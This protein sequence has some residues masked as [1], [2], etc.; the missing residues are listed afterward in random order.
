MI[1][2]LPGVSVCVRACMRACACAR[3]RARVCV[4]VCVCV[5]VR[6]YARARAGC[7]SVC[8]GRTAKRHGEC[9]N[10]G[11]TTKKHGEGSRKIHEFINRV[12]SSGDSFNDPDGTP[13]TRT[14]QRT[15]E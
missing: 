10:F 5:C 4:C 3:A 11:R 12:W 14:N 2:G 8:V 15:R 6:A 1:T 9:S 7:V 13:Q